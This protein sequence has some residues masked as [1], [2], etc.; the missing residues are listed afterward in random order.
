MN[1]TG[2]L[3]SGI[4]DL[5]SLLTS[6]G[7]TL[8]AMTGSSGI[9]TN[10]AGLVGAFFI[11]QFLTRMYEISKSNGGNDKGIAYIASPFIFGMLLVNFFVVQQSITDT[12]QLS[13]GVLSPSMPAPYLTTMWAAVKTVAHGF[14]FISVFRGLMLAKTAAEGQSS[15][16]QSPA[17][18][19]F[20][21]IIGGVLLINL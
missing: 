5:A 18:G 1:A 3:L 15:G 9:V 21:H 6:I 16:H 8:S 14:G 12:F 17:W 11:Y 10:I 13:G 2:S 19:S 7:T 20:W 4:P